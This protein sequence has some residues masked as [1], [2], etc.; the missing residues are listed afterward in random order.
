MKLKRVRKAVQKAKCEKAIRKSV[1]ELLKHSVGGAMSPSVD[2]L[3][4]RFHALPERRPQDV[5]SIETLRTNWLTQR[6]SRKGS[7]LQ[8]IGGI[9]PK[10]SP[11][12]DASLQLGSRR[13]S[14]LKQVS[15]TCTWSKEEG[16][17]AFSSCFQRSEVSPTEVVHV[18]TSLCNPKWNLARKKTQSSERLAIISTS[19]RDQQASR[20]PPAVARDRTNI[21]IQSLARGGLSRKKHTVL[22]KQVEHADFQSTSVNY[23]KAQSHRE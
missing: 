1:Q 9:F 10:Q 12:I 7:S 18:T 21:S 22:E 16:A 11:M 5:E 4:A 23:W 19:V 2:T 15:S 20:T 6:A 3:R 8:K 14:P 13:S 17:H